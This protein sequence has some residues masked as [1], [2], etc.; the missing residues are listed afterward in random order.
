MTIYNG[1]GCAR[2]GGPRLVVR[3]GANRGVE[4]GAQYRLRN[5]SENVVG[6]LLGSPPKWAAP[7][8]AA[9]SQPPLAIVIRPG[10]Q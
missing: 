7:I 3:A 1:L 5:Y 6:T 10:R 9:T 2:S 4:R 8:N